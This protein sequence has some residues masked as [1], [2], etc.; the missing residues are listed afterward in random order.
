MQTLATTESQKNLIE[1]LIGDLAQE[2]AFQNHIKFFHADKSTLQQEKQRNEMKQHQELVSTI[3]SLIEENNFENALELL[4]QMKLFEFVAENEVNL[5]RKRII[6]SSKIFIKKQIISSIQKEEPDFE[7]TESAIDLAVSLS[8]E[9]ELINKFKKHIKRKR[10]S[11]LCQRVDKAVNDN[12]FDYAMKIISA[13]SEID[14]SVREELKDSL[15][16]KW[17]SFSNSEKIQNSIIDLIRS[18]NNGQNTES[19]S[20]LEGLMNIVNKK[21]KSKGINKNTIDAV[22]KISDSLKKSDFASYKKAENKLLRSLTKKEKTTTES[23]E[24]TSNPQKES[25]SLKYNSFQKKFINLMKR[26]LYKSGP[27]KYR[28]KTS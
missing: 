25:D 18:L 16:K 26:I 10:A 8:L 5:F 23:N 24:D 11:V 4:D 1:E 7:A 14:E 3:E 15:T 6:E 20:P 19:S 17:V 9:N 27:S 22:T 2:K 12:A 21:M 13:D 28:K